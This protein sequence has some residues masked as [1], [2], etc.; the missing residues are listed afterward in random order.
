[1]ISSDDLHE[2][3]ILPQLCPLIGIHLS[4]HSNAQNSFTV[5]SGIQGLQQ[6]KN[7]IPSASSRV[8]TF[9]PDLIYSSSR[10]LSK[11]FIPSLSS[12][13]QQLL[14]P[15]LI[16]VM[17]FLLISPRTEAAEDSFLDLLPPQLPRNLHHLSYNAGTLF[18]CLSVAA[19]PLVYQ[20]LSPLSYLKTPLQQCFLYQ[21]IPIRRQMSCHIFH[22]RNTLSRSLLPRLPAV[23]ISL[24]SPFQQNFFKKL[25]KTMDSN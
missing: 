20:I 7:L 25:C 9:F 22:L 21:V 18:T 23:P 2:V 16:S 10:L 8:I 11:Y 17:V 15:S 14:P 1:M 19:P 12:K 24:H 3:L 4:P 6:Q 5:H 13:F